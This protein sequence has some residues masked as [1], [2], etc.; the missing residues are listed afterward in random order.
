MEFPTEFN[1]GHLKYKIIYQ[2]EMNADDGS[3]L[4]G[5]HRLHEGKIFIIDKDNTREYVRIVL[6]H[7]ILHAIEYTSGLD[8]EEKEIR[9]MSFGFIQ[10]LR[11]NPWLAPYLM[12][13]DK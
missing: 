2:D 4:G 1:F 9:G 3:P 10:A 5:Q 12:D 7:E 6:L 13:V 8:M 11:Q